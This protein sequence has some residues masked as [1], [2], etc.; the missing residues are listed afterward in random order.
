MLDAFEDH[1]NS[2]TPVCLICLASA[3]ASA[4]VGRKRL[5]LW[6]LQKPWM[7]T[8]KLLIR[9]IPRRQGT[10]VFQSCGGGLS[11]VLKPRVLSE[12][13]SHGVQSLVSHAFDQSS[14]HGRSATLTKYT[15]KLLG[16]MRAE[17]QRYQ[18]FPEAGFRTTLV[19]GSLISLTLLQALWTEQSETRE[20]AST[21]TEA[22]ETA[23]T[24]E[25]TATS[26]ECV[27]A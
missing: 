2:E 16:P 3:I 20:L 13:V 8:L 24:S 25:T 10:P 21:E 14:T 27:V 4:V 5:H 23:A 15:L 17:L 19:S 9:M 1:M 11:F 18:I 6:L 12:S 22:Q 26:G 7:V